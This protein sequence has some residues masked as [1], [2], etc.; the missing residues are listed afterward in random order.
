MVPPELWVAWCCCPQVWWHR[1]KGQWDADQFPLNHAG[2]QIP[3]M[4]F[5]QGQVSLIRVNL[6]RLT[7]VPSN[8][9]GHWAHFF[10]LVS[11]HLNIVR[12]LW[13][14]P[15]CVYSEHWC[16]IHT[17]LYISQKAIVAIWASCRSTN[18]TN[19]ANPTTFSHGNSFW[20]LWL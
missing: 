12:M 7:N 16:C 3:T 13:E 1:W 19:G 18:K 2:T 5:V 10:C 11:R 6:H 14:L 17:V 8:Y 4:E 9:F 20:F 15:V